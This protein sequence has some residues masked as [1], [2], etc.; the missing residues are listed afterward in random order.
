MPSH[1]GKAI[2]VNLIFFCFFA[3]ESR[4]FD[5]SLALSQ[6]SS[7]EIIVHLSGLQDSCAIYSFGSSTI[8][9]SGS[10]FFISTFGMPIPQPCPPGQPPQ[11]PV[12]YQLN[13]S[14]GSLQD[15]DY[16]VSWTVPILG[17]QPSV[18]NKTFA[19]RSGLLVGTSVSVP[20]LNEWGI[21][22]FAFFAGLISLYRL[23]RQRSME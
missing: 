12:P 23:R 8:T 20:A 14:F 7:G 9:H 11:P 16:S 6:S 15:G 19:I 1:W 17:T 21:I 18:V 22:V 5:E 13:V 3:G 10:A 4:A 2:L